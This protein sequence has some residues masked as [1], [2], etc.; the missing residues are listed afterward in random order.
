M[1]IVSIELA[2]EGALFGNLILLAR[3]PEVFWIWI[4]LDQVE[5]GLREPFAL[6]QMG[7]G[8]VGDILA[9]LAL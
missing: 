6:T 9:N 8:E 1:I 3:I 4:S 7:G 5:D 2:A